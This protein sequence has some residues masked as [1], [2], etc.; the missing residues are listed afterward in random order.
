MNRAMT[1]RQTVAHLLDYVEDVLGP[2][3]RRSLE[4]HLDECPRCVEFVESYRATPGIVRR[5][6]R[7][8]PMP[9]A[10]RR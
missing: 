4:A 2:N 8:M 10:R 5:A 3:E 1:C 9:P 7:A 6:T